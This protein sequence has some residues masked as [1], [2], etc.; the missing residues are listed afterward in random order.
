MQSILKKIRQNNLENN[1]WPSINKII[2]VLLEHSMR[3]DYF[4]G[5][6]LN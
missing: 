5:G 6:G 3:C 2:N 1:V 4:K